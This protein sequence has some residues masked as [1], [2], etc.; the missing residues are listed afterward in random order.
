MLQKVRQA[1]QVGRVIKVPRLHAGGSSC[2][3]GIWVTDQQCSH[4]VVESTRASAQCIVSLTMLAVLL[5]GEESWGGW[6][7]VGCAH[8][9]RA[10]TGQSCSLCDQQ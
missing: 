7:C 5:I 6:Q 2:K 8:A 9:M 10:L 4:A 3:H 1:W